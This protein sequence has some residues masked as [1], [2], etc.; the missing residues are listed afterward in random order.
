MPD[1]VGRATRGLFRDLMTDSTL[2]QIA[3]AFEDEG[4]APNPF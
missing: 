4:F 3:A 1:L 2:G